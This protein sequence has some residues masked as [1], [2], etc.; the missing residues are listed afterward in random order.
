[1]ALTKIPSTLIDTTAGLSLS[2][3]IT[4]V[5]NDKA[6]FGTGSDLQIYHDGSHSYI[7]ENGTGN[8]IL[9]GGGQIL[10]KSPADENMIVA[11][12]NGAVNLYYDNA[13]KLATTSTGIDVTGVITTDG[14]TTSADINFG[15]SD[16]AIFGAGSDLQIYHDGSASYIDDAGTGN[17]RIRANSSLSIQKYTGETMGVFTADGSVLLAHDNSTK[18]ETTATGIDVTGVITT[19]GLTTSADINFGDSDKA[20]FGAGSDLQIYHDSSNSYIVDSGTGDLNIQATNLSIKNASGGSNYLRAT[21]GGALLI[22]YSGA[23]KLATSN[24]GV[25]ITGEIEATSFSDGTISGITFIDEDSFATNSATR[26]PTQQSI[27]AYVDTQVAGVVDS[28]PA[29]LDT[30]N[31]LAAALGDDANFSTTTSTALGNRLRVDTAAQGLTG[32]Q[33][34]NAITN[35]GITATKAELNYVDGVTSNIQTQLDGKQASGS[36]LTGNQTIT[37]SGDV[38]GSG[39]TSIA[40]TIADDSH[41]HVISNVDG[42][43]T[44]L[45]AKLASSSYTAADVLTKI[46]TVDGAGSGLDADLLDGISSGSFLRSDAND[47]VTNTSLETS[48]YSNDVMETATGGQATLEVF[49]DTAGADAFMQFHV[50]GD[51]AAYFGLKGDIN[52]FAVGGWSMGANYYRVWHA[53]NDG[54]GSGLDADLLDAQ[55]GSY[56]LDYNNFTNRPT[57]GGGTPYLD[58]A[59][60]NYGTVKVD[61]DRGISWAGYAIRD[62]WVFMSDGASISGIYNDTDNN[63]AAIFRRNAETELFHNGA[64]KMETTSSGISVTGNVVATGNVTAYSSDER[65][66]TNITP[67][68][69]PIEKVKQLNGVEFDWKDNVEELGFTPRVKH[70]TGVIAQNVQSVIPDATPNAPFNEEYLTVQHEKIIPVLIE[71][72]KEQQKQIDELKQALHEQKEIK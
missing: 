68:E 59:T 60:G 47:A 67:I 51:Y 50:S 56:Y 29:A 43:Q 22:Y 55:Q 17:L 9:K 63:W 12:G 62:D 18:L 5:D 25:T 16:K 49:Q 28:A 42:L 53:G 33:Q 23:Q 45:D 40:V 38:S 14:L 72:I 58:V 20:I 10:L 65:L 11:T 41:N 34:A 7:Y 70:E 27:K 52:D 69:N 3:D 37:L 48:F 30:L 46:K 31:E 71:A 36:Y 6:I 54:A 61:D 1:M 8:L 15:D 57:L 24:T 26:V 4:L 66:K 32:T 2:G 44:A 13:L 21:T 64:L 19:D 39:T 35:L